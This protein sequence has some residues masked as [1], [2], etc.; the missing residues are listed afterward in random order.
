[1]GVHT[2]DPE[3]TG[4]RRQEASIQGGQA[5]SFVFMAVILE[6]T[7]EIPSMIASAPSPRR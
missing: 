6:G 2:K 3:H 4:L 7:N 5:G 1:M